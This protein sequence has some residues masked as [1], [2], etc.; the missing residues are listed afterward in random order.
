[1]GHQI[2]SEAGFH[3]LLTCAWLT[4]Y[5]SCC[6]VAE[7]EGTNVCVLVQFS[8]RWYL[9]TQESQ[10]AL[11]P[12]SSKFSQR[13]LGSTITMLVWLAMALS[14]PFEEE[15]QALPLSMPLSSRW[16]MVRCLRPCAHR[17]W[18]KLLNTSHLLRHSNN[19][20]THSLL[21]MLHS[22]LWTQTNV[23][24]TFYS[25]WY[26]VIR[27]MRTCKM[28]DSIGLALTSDAQL[29]HYSPCCTVSE[30]MSTHKHV[31]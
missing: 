18:L 24:L 22:K 6:V 17:Y 12:V 11:H 28:H 25:Q 8:L 27:L 30:V 26:T 7:V 20:T 15:H 21:T 19:C 9:H 14:H 3:F 16:L 31:L 10:Q 5:S 4:L 2:K 1:M 29:T 23:W 13:C